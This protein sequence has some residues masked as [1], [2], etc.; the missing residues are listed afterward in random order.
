M[1]G[2]ESGKEIVDKSISEYEKHFNKSFPL[3]EYIHLAEEDGLVTE[4]GANKFKDFIDL[5]IKNNVEVITPEDYYE[6][7]Y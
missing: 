1:I 6:R 7:L 2:Y 5:Q 3:F 4:N